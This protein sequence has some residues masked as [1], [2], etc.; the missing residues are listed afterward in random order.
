[1]RPVSGL[2]WPLSMSKQV[3]L[4]APFGP[5]SARISPASQRE[6]H[7][8]HGVDAAIGFG[9]AFDRQQVACALIR[10]PRRLASTAIPAAM[11]AP[12]R[13][14]HLQRADDALRE[15][16]DDQHDEA[17]EHELRQVGL[18][19]QPDVERLVDD[20]AD[21]RARDRLDAAEQHHHQRIDRERDAEIVGKDAALEIGEQRAGDARDRAGD[22]ERRPLDALAVDADGFAAQRRVARGP[23]RIAERREHDERAGRDRT[24]PRR[25]ATASRR[26]AGLA[27]H[28]SGQTPRMPLSPP[29]TATHW[30]AIDQTICAKASVSIAK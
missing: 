25:R 24:A 4:P 11:L 23:Q 13:D 7:A 20:G 12:A 28:F 10:R 18:A 2:F 9:Q 1:M 30:N 29:V 15:G 27:A 21:D 3:L 16:D 5:I 22:D 6:R 14:Q 19:D 8:A 17:A 26:C